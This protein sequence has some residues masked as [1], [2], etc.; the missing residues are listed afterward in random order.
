[1]RIL[2]IGAGATGGFY[3][4]RLAHAGRDVTFLV[5]ER[6]AAQLRATGL[7]VRTPTEEFTVTPKLISAEELK[8][9]EPFDLILLSVKAY[10]FDSAVEDF[11][12]AVGPQTMILPLLNGMRHLDAL[13]ATFGAE[14]VL[15]GF[16]RIIG[17]MDDQG[18][19]LQMT[20]MSDIFYGERDKTVTARIQAVDAQMQGAGFSAKLAPDILE[21]MWGKWMM[22]AAINTINPLGRG[23]VG[24]IEAVREMDGVGARF[25]NRV[26]DESFVVAAACGYA[27]SAA[28]EAMIRGRL[29]E[30]GS[31]FESS[32]YRDLTRGLPVE[33]DQIVGDM[34]LRG[35]RLG[36]ETP[37]LEAAYVQLKVYE[38]KLARKA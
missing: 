18:R 4:G 24:E 10:A 20:P 29:T 5:R 1:M 19:V 7:R 16:C 25:L 34:I 14:H 8:I 22:M 2:V 38:E 32:L 3:G 9:T 21:G 28:T 27:P 33:A 36:V 23:S 37:L 35:R 11:A 13:D 15:G 17:D 26:A 30:P 6:R 12:V 31:G